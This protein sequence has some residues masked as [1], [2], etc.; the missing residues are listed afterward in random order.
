M[1][2]DRERTV[3]SAASPAD[4]TPAAVPAD[5][6]PAAVPADVTPA[7]VPADARPP[8]SLH[9]IAASAAA[10]DPAALRDYYNALRHVF[11][12]PDQMGA[13][14]GIEIL[15]LTVEKVVMRMPWRR[16]LRRWGDIFHGGAIM[17]LADHVGGCLFTADPRVIAA[18]NAGVTTDFHTSFLR[19]AA[20]GEGLIAEGIAQRRGRSMT[21][22]E[23]DVRTEG[24]GTLVARCMTTYL[25][26]PFGSIGAWRGG[27]FPG[28]GAS[29]AEPGEA[30]T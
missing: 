25:A 21:F 18:G 4:A 19:A 20:P 14:L 17:A 10:G 28:E 6:T 23:V 12:G 13:H 7:A 22:I 9:A 29:P 26:L 16:E 24:A 8:A 1:A 3:K 2:H 27:G 11:G 15:E 30:A 5:A